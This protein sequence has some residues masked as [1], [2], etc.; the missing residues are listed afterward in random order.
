L[1]ESANPVKPTYPTSPQLDPLPIPGIFPSD[2]IDRV[3]ED[4]GSDIGSLSYYQG[5]L[6]YY[7]NLLAQYNQSYLD[8]LAAGGNCS[9]HTNIIRGIERQIANINRTIEM[10]TNPD[11]GN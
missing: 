4:S 6:E 5:L 9:P 11:Y 3:R 1:V 8:C 2:V 10:L 7:Q